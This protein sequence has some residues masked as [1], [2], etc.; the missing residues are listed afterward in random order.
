MRKIIFF[1]AILFGAITFGCGFAGEDE[2]DNVVY[3]YNWGDYLSPETLT[4]FEEE[5]GIRVILDEY[6]TNESMYPRIAEGAVNLS[7]GLYDSE[8]GGEQSFATFGFFKNA[9]C[10]RI[11][12]KRF[13]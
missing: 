4:M 2:D 12:R 8:N 11:Y 13:F 10:Q 5:T 9:Q 1:V 6:D 3:V 7:V